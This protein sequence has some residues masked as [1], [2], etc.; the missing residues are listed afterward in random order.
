MWAAGD[1]F[2]MRAKQLLDMVYS[3]SRPSTCQ[4]LLLMGYREI[5]IGAMAQS[6]LYVGMAVRM[7]IFFKK[8]VS[9]VVAKIMEI[10]RLRIL[11]CIA[12]LIIG[13][14]V[15]ARSSLLLSSNF[16]NGYGMPVLLWTNMYPHTLDDLF[17]FLRAITTLLYQVVM[18]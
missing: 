8:N 9:M 15:K 7:V 12:R 17:R 1:G 6:W 5:G 3:N 16:V 10:S 2:L 13:H 4:A 18:R 14:R 11:V